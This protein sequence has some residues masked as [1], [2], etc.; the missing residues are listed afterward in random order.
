ML[1]QTMEFISAMGTIFQSYVKD[2]MTLDEFCTKAQEYV[3]TY[4]Q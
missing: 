1:P 4:N 2:E 3:E